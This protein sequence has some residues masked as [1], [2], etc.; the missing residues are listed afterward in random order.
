MTAYVGRTRDQIRD[1]LLSFWA[2]QYSARGERLL[3]A[4]G[5]DPYLQAA[6]LAVLLESLEAQAEQVERD[7][8]PGQ[9]S[10]DALNRHGYV[11][12][13]T[14]RAGTVAAFSLTVTNA[15]DGTKAIPAGTQA[16]YSDGT[17]YNI[18]STSVVISGGTG[19][20]TAKAV[21]P[22]TSGSRVAG[23]VLTFVATP[24]GLDST[25]TVAASPV[26][27]PGVGEESDADYAARIIARRQERPASGNRA[28]WQDW[29]EGYQ[30]TTITRAYVYPLLEP[31]TS[32]PGAGVADTLGCVTVVAV[33]PAQGDSL[34][35][36]R[37]VPTDD[38]TTRTAGAALPLIR[39]YIEGTHSITGV[40]PYAGEQLRPVTML[41]ADAGVEAISV[42][43][44]NVVL[45]CVMTA[46]NDFPW[47]GAL[48]I[49]LSTDTTVKVSGDHTAKE[50]LL[51]LVL[52][53]TPTARGGY[54]AVT[55]GTAVYAAGDT[56]FTQAA[57]QEVGFPAGSV[58]PC[59]GNWPTI[60]TAVFAHFDALGPG[61][62]SPPARWPPESD[63]ARATLYRT[64]LAADV[65]V[66]DGTTPTGV[67]SC[68]V[69][70]PAANLTP[71]AK[72]VVTLGTL[73][74]T[75]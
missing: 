51:A 30:G 53:A 2:A 24:T 15:V 55:L 16:T 41:A 33:G 35:A 54:R 46:A 52:P 62:T 11:D 23:G 17:Q 59:P 34:T 69:T 73:L 66:G 19:T 21:E 12:G 1:A 44:Q 71:A 74:V 8:L 57:G 13:V 31:P 45:G 36:T 9:A 42:Q 56:T 48:A 40:T 72:T 3:T 65:I 37:I 60:R 63:E 49:V 7:I 39:G 25:A 67:L 26:P 50:G 68:T 47:S 4:P 58:Y 27:T 20:I 14:R 43:S 5:S 75:P 18:T 64:A 32:Y 22:G 28:D 29:V 61:D 6:A 70:T 38:L 10:T